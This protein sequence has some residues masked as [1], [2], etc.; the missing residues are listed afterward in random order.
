MKFNA[1]IPELIV[2]NF[3]IAIKDYD[4]ALGRLSSVGYPLFRFSQKNRYTVKEEVM[5]QEEFLVQDL[6]GYLLRFVRD[7]AS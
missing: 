7:E 5:M 1:L 4:E 3:E 6:D 2:F